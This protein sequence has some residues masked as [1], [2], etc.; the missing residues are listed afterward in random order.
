MTTGEILSRHVLRDRF[1]V[2]MSEMYSEEIPAYSA[3]VE[4]VGKQ[5][6]NAR[7]KSSKQHVFPEVEAGLAYH[8]A[9]RLGSDE[10]LRM[11]R[12]AFALMGMQPVGYYDL[13]AAG[14]PVHSTAFRPITTEAIELSPFRIFTSLLRLDMLEDD[15]LK[16]RINNI[17]STREVFTPRVVELIEIA[18]SRSGLTREQGEEFVLE[19]LETFRWRN[20]A[21]VS[22]DE[23]KVFDKSYRL[24]ADIV[25]FHG[26]HINHLTVGSENIDEAHKAIGSCGVHAKSSIEGP[27]KRQCPILLRQTA[28]KAIEETVMFP[29]GQG[30]NELGSHTARFGEVEARG[31]ALTP[32]GRALYDRLLAEAQASKDSGPEALQQAFAEFPDDWDMLREKGLAYF[33]YRLAPPARGFSNDNHE[34]WDI[35]SLI[36]EGVIEVSPVRYED[37]LPVSAAGIFRS[38]L[39]EDA[40]VSVKG[41]SRKAEFEASLGTPV[42]DPFELYQAVETNSLSYCAQVLGIEIAYAA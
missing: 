13:S 36:D 6:V 7:S 14:L 41:D 3:L 40:S 21:H 15:D 26:P 4:M 2:A 30:G 31:A 10:D 42:L 38:N 33:R 35:D 34:A 24:L 23:Y 39:G 1:A 5:N 8:G 19:L 9:I 22:L 32:K 20:E 27:P 28:F 25:S 17:L 16:H 29:D 18:E 12:R 11:M 37:F